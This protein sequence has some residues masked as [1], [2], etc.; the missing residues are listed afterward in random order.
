VTRGEAMELPGSGYL[1]TIAALA[2]TF[3]GFTTIVLVFRQNM[4]ASPI[5][6]L[7]SHG[8]MEHGFSAAAFA[9]LAP[10]L[11]TFGLSVPVI[12]RSTS[13]I[14]AIV[15]IGHHWF[16]VHRFL[17][18]TGR[19]PLRFLINSGISV[20]VIVVLLANAVGSPFDPQLGPVAAAATLRLFIGAEIFMLTFE[21][22]FADSKLAK[23]KIK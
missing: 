23:R 18:T 14:I 8:Y 17:R 21:E 9:M 2:M 13:L 10:L 4:K 7:H 12:W 11:A 3:V 20:I 19:P 16:T 22:F 5:T 1:Y 6:A 15:I